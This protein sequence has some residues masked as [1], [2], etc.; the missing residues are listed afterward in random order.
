MFSPPNIR[1]FG[2]S[3]IPISIGSSWLR[4][5]IGS[6]PSKLR[7]GGIFVCLFL[8]SKSSA[9]QQ[10]WRCGKK[11]KWFPPKSSTFFSHKKCWASIHG[12]PHGFWS[13]AFKI[14]PTPQTPDPRDPSWDSAIPGDPAKLPGPILGGTWERMVP[15]MVGMVMICG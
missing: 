11:K 7:K 2:V 3:N 9:M 12:T 1:V 5:D 14:S 15:G 10:K 8:S 13:K 6:H 4:L